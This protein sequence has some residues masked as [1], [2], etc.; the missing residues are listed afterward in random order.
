MGA[1]YCHR[2]H[3]ARV[4]QMSS[5][6]NFICMGFRNASVS[7]RPNSFRGFTFHTKIDF[8]QE[9]HHPMVSQ[10][11]IPTSLSPCAR[12]FKLLR[13]ACVKQRGCKEATLLRASRQAPRTRHSA[14]DLSAQEF[15]AIGETL[16]WAKSSSCTR[17]RLQT[18]VVQSLAVCICHAHPLGL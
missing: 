14:Q 18:G 2:P 8:Q 1:I 5:V 11:I 6:G 9:G 16:E 12:V 3:I 15:I 17:S 4:L 10:S 7:C 13:S